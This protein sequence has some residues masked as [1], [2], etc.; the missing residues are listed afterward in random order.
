MKDDYLADGPFWTTSCRRPLRATLELV[1]ARAAPALCSPVPLLES[2]RLRK[3]QLIIIKESRVQERSAL[4]SLSLTLFVTSSSLLNK[5]EHVV[6]LADL[7]SVVQNVFIFLLLPSQSDSHSSSLLVYRC[8]LV[9][10]ILFPF[11]LPQHFSVL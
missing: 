1:P 9:S 10:P 5:L 8:T 6:S 3:R 4:C 7:S 11:T 2:E